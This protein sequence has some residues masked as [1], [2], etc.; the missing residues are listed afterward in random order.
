M[1][2]QQLDH[3]WHAIHKTIRVKGLDRLLLN[4]KNLKL[5]TQSAAWADMQSQF[6]EYGTALLTT[7]MSTR[8][9]SN[10]SCRVGVQLGL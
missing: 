2:T 9:I 1:A 5:R 8:P 6:Q 4:A 7:N 10:K 3:I